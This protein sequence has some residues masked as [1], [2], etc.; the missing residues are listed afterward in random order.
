MEKNYKEIDL[1]DLIM[2]AIRK[3]YQKKFTFLG[4]FSVFLIMGFFYTANKKDTYAVR[5]MANSSINSEIN[6]QLF[7]EIN[8]TNI[9]TKN[10][11]PHLLSIKAIKNNHNNQLFILELI[12]NDTTNFEQIKQKIQSTY[13]NLPYVKQKLESKKEE[14]HLLVDA[15]DKGIAESK[16]L[17]DSLLNTKSNSTF[18]VAEPPVD[19]RIQKIILKRKLQSLSSIEYISSGKIVFEKRNNTAKY[20]LMF[21]LAGFVFALSFILL[22]RDNSR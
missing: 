8:Q 16:T 20:W 22:K 10:I 2:V 15:Y 11:S 6:F 5:L 14:L 12:L 19:F 13:S 18:V 3:V 1:I 21:A 4:I 7:S 17:K 9:Q